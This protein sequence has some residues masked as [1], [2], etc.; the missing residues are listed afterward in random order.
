MWRVRRTSSSA[1]LRGCWRVA[2]R[3]RRST[4]G[5]VYTCVP[6]LHLW[7]PKLNLRCRGVK[8]SD[9]RRRWGAPGPEQAEH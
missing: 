9:N 7:T 6:G 3:E 8:R 4:Y 2:A 5:V 1:Y